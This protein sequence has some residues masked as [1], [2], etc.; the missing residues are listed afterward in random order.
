MNRNQF[1]RLFSAEEANGLIPLL[2]TIIGELQVTADILRHDVAGLV[3]VDPQLEDLG[4]GQ[5]LEAHPELR[6]TAQRMAELTDQIESLGCLLKDIDLG[7]VDFPSQMNGEVVFLC[8]RFGEPRVV[9]W[10]TLEEGF[11]GRKPLP[12]APKTHLN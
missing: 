9:A 4:V 12:G 11:S 5:L 3:P 8:W 6:K 10:H 1:E 2:E 7:L